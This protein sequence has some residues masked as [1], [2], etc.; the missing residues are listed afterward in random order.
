MSDEMAIEVLHIGNWK[1]FVRGQDPRSSLF[2]W[3]TR[4]HRGYAHMH[5][6]IRTSFGQSSREHQRVHGDC[7]CAMSK[8]GTPEAVLPEDTSYALNVNTYSGKTYLLIL[9]LST[10]TYWCLEVHEKKAE[11]TTITVLEV[12]SESLGL[13][14]TSLSDRGGEF[15]EL[16]AYVKVG[17]YWFISIKEY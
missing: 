6:V 13:E 12:W 17:R 10:D 2:S 11:P 14:L 4:F 7:G 8:W 3:H 1:K 15:E 5:R 9:Q 16:S